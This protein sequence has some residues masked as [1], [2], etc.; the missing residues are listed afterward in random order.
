MVWQSPRVAR[1]YHHGNLRAALVGAATE[2]LERGGPLGVTLRGAARRA[3]VS[4][5]AP[6]RHFR[7]KEALLAAVAEEGFRGVVRSGEAVARNDADPIAT[8]HGLARAYI[9]YATEH[10]S[11]YRLMFS[12]AVRGRAHPTLRE[13]AGDAWVRFAGAIERCQHEGRVRAGDPAALAFVFWSMLHGLAMLLPAPVA[14]MP[15]DAVVEHATN[16][17]VEGLKAASHPRP[18]RPPGPTPRPRRRVS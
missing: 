8:L 13:A 12:P 9:R 10:P 14:Q 11:H 15:I 1:P 16:V 6:Y 17:L 4:Q 2:L 18:P 3:G 7:D 5:A